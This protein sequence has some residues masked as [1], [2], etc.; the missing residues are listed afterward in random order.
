MPDSVR[1]AHGH[2]GT[3]GFVS[4]IEQVEIWLARKR[5]EN[6]QIRDELLIRKGDPEL[7]E[8]L[9][10]NSADIGKCH[11][12]LADTR[13]EFSEIDFTIK[14]RKPLNRKRHR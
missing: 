13:R 6:D 14:E 7:E 10:A 4:E 1:G 8:K 11:R 9:V 2:Q 3:G 5:S 12:W